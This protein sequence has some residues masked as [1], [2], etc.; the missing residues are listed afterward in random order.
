MIFFTLTFSLSN[1]QVL[2]VLPNSVKILVEIWQPWNCR[3]MIGP[4]H[5]AR[6][7]SEEMWH[8]E[9]KKVQYFI[10]SLYCCRLFKTFTFFIVTSTNKPLYLRIGF[11]GFCILGM[12]LDW[13]QYEQKILLL[14]LWLVTD[15][16]H[17]LWQESHIS[18]SLTS[19]LL[20][21]GKA[22][23]W[24]SHFASAWHNAQLVHIVNCNARH[25]C[26][27]LQYKFWYRYS[28]V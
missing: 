28:V 24:Y 4:R 14:H 26:G 8:R 23:V 2:G 10:T 3:G 13:H 18:T 19:S 6:P 15:M 12:T 7:F 22:S 9:L 5:F 27:A 11:L 1:V 16:L 17:L 21:S 25:W 20:S